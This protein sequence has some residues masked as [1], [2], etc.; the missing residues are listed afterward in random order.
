MPTAKLKRK[1]KCRRGAKAELFPRGE[2]GVVCG[3]VERHLVKAAFRELAMLPAHEA[4]ART[5]D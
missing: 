3:A 5:E 4:L 2:R 1:S